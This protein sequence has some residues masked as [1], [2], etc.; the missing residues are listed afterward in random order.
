MNLGTNGTNGD[1]DLCVG[2]IFDLAAVSNA[3]GGGNPSWIVGDTFLVS[4]DWFALHP[5]GYKLENSTEKC[6]H[7]A[8]LGPSLHRF[9]ATIRGS[10]RYLKHRIF[11]F[12]KRTR[13]DITSGLLY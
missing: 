2:G 8:T 6:L 4:S 7:G 5:S 11:L 9:C 12:L 1:G 13:C 10:W 3:G